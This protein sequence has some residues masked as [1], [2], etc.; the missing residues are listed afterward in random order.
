LSLE[1]GVRKTLALPSIDY[2][3]EYKLERAVAWK[4]EIAPLVAKAVATKKFNNTVGTVSGIG[5]LLTGGYMALNVYRSNSGTD[6]DSYM[7]LDSPKAVADWK[8][9]QGTGGTPASSE[10]F[11]RVFGTLGLSLTAL[12]IFEFLAPVP[13]LHLAKDLKEVDT[14]IAENQKK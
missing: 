9:Q 10:Y 3:P 8:Y 12:S 14:L 11:F 7:Q 4:E 5:V 6:Y 1:P 13:N 2:S